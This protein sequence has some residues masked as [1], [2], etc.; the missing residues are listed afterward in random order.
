MH[1]EWLSAT[2]LFLTAVVIAVPL[3]QRLGLGAILG[4]LVAGT[5][6][7]PQG[8][9]LI[10]SPENVREL[11]EL[12]VVLMLFIIGLELVPS[13]LW[14]MRRIVFGSGTAQMAAT[15]LVIGGILW[16]TDLGIHGTWIAGF[17]LA[18]SSTAM[19]LQLLT[20]RNELAQSQGRIALAVLLF[21]DLAVIP[22]LSLL[23]LVAGV[24]ARGGPGVWTVL[25]VLIVALVGGH[26]LLRP[27]LRRVAAA[28]SRELFTASSLLLVLGVAALMSSVGLSMALGAFMAGVLLAD[29]EFRHELETNIEPF[30][31]LLLGLFF[32]S[33]GMDLSPPNGGEGWLVVSLA[34][35]VLVAAKTV[36]LFGI[37]KWMGL[38]SRNARALALTLSQGSEFAFVLFGLAAGHSLLTEEHAT[39][40]NLIV[41]LSMFTTPLLRFACDRWLEPFLATKKPKPSERVF[42][43]LPG[44]TVPVVI[45]GFGRFSQII[46]RIL[47]TQK[48]PFTALDRDLSHIQ[49][50]SR[51]G[52]KVYY[53]D[54][55][56]LDLLRTAQVEKAQIFVLGFGDINASLLTAQ[57][58]RQHFP[59]VK[60]YARAVNR[61]HAYRL[62]NLG[63]QHVVRETFGSSLELAEHALMELGLTD[64]AASDTV[65]V[66]RDFDEKLLRKSSKHAG[67][68]E[69]L[70]EINRR[71]REELESL[72]AQDRDKE[73]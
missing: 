42:D 67:N 7:G 55:S 51:F 61:D 31:G 38:P 49:F 34:V 30:K 5:V 19:A 73:H 68:T 63:V 65:R 54:A 24:D 26:F 66:F 11:S 14:G 37:G 32:M 8:L 60:I 28:R 15:G 72:F 46:A 21:Q 3:F 12:G 13:R 64:N 48:I 16:S 59:K 25:A 57:L 33:V 58:V 1:T 18:M 53:G 50:V 29:S 47:Q 45:A 17:G 23:P 71:G 40:L 56:R 43:K 62:L 41:S 44:T 52:N 39:R 27:M 4:Y 36:V 9:G 70:A 35:L 10:H 20:E 22:L 6:I 69:K 2:L